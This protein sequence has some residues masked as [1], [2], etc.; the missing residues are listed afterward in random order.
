MPLFELLGAASYSIYLFHWA[1]FGAAKPVTAV[2]APMANGPAKV[3]LLMGAHFA[4]ALLA[5]LVIHVLIEKPFT[6]WATRRFGGRT[7]RVPAVLSA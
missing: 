4:I 6:R 7:H 3:A 2:L 5:G 1:S